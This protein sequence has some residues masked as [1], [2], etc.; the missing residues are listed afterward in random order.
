MNKKNIH[1]SK[2][3]FPCNRNLWYSCNG[4]EEVVSERTQRIFDVGTYLEPLAVKWLQKDGWNVAYN[5]GSQN[6][7]VTIRVPING[8]ELIGHPDALIWRDGEKAILV[9]IKTMN[10]R[11]FTLWKREG[12]IKKYPQYV[13]Q[14]HI[15]A[16]TPAYLEYFNGRSSS[17]L[18][19]ITNEEREY[20]HHDDEIL[21]AYAK[22]LGHIKKLGIVGVNKNT[23]EMR[24]DTFD[25][26]P[27]RTKEIINRAEKIL[28][29]ED[30]PEPGE[31]MQNWS[32][33]YCGYSWLCE[34]AKRERDT[35]VGEG[36]ALTNDP[37]IIN[38]ME[39]LKEARELSK[40][41][42]ELE[43]EAKQALDENVRK[44]GIKAIRGGNYIL[45]LAETKARE[46]F[47]KTAFGK[48]HPDLLK[49]FTKLG[50]STLRYD[51]KEVQ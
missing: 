10:D 20:S 38:A 16:A 50:N 4:H 6:A 23:S 27:E 15:Y 44:Q 19:N 36:I 51:I 46:T 13:D 17:S 40:T 33:N 35:S 45:T 31:R 49:D 41:G 30:V 8:G 48:A 11:A 9:D 21:R 5:Q 12:T 25:Y 29:C 28:A 26:N 18:I 24:I 39:L 3:G 2:I 32:C 1:A 43:E 47:D 7:H 22:N 34:L 37:V 42:K 14:L